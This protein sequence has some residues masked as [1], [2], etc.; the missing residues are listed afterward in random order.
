MTQ[1]LT[2]LIT[3][4]KG[5]SNYQQG[6]V[7]VI[8]P[9]TSTQLALPA[10]QSHWTLGMIAQHI[11]ANRVWWFQV[12]MGEGN[13]DLAPIANWDPQETEHD[14]TV[15]T[16]ELVTAL[17]STWQMIAD[18]L[19]RWTAADLPHTFP[20][21]SQLSAE[22]QKMFGHLS[23]Q[24]LI[25]HTLEHEIFHGGELSLGLGNY[26]LPGIYGDM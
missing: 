11:V 4:Y 13:P 18:S 12:W 19:A 14:I 20:P 26:G 25:W 7:E 10:S 24:W 2:P 3:F 6:L 21:P 8:T 22:E 17:N 5:W 15:D 9:L 23:R 16:P 1:Q